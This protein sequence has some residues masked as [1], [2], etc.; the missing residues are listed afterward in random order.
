MLRVLKII[1]LLIVCNLKITAQNT[2]SEEIKALLSDQRYSQAQWLCQ[3][4]I[5]NDSKDESIYY[6]NAMCAKELFAVDAVYLYEQFLLEF[7]FTLFKN[8][9]YEDLA[10]IHL[11]DMYY[12][13]AINYLLK[14]PSLDDYPFLVFK[15][16]YAYFSVDSLD[17]SK[18]YFTKLLNI[19]SKY[20]VTSIYYTAHIDY[21]NGM[22]DSALKGFMKLI[23]DKQFGSIVPYYI[24]Q[25]YFFQR[26]YIQLIDFTAPIIDHIVPSRKLEVNRLLAESYYRTNQYNNAVVYFRSYI[27]KKDQINPIV[28]F[29]L[30]KSYFEISDYANAIQYLEK[31]SN[32]NDS[33]SQ[34]AA[35]SLGA[36][37][38][39]THQY[40]YALYAFK[41]ASTYS[42]DLLIKEDAYYNY[43]KLSYQLD[44][45]LD[46]TLAALRNYLLDYDNALHRKEV[47]SLMA[48]TFQSGS[49]YEEAYN[50][51]KDVT[52]LNNSQKKSFQRISF[53]L[54]VRE[55]NNELYDNALNYFQIAS[56]HPID[57]DINYLN[58]FWLADCYY[59]LN[60]FEK[61]V[62]FYS[63]L[64]L[65]NLS[66]YDFYDD[67]SKYNLAYAYFQQGEYGLANKLFRQYEKIANDSMRIQDT[68]LRIAD[69]FFMNKKYS[70][71]ENYY[72]KAVSYALFDT[73]YAMYQRSIA[74]GLIGNNSTKADLL[75]LLTS[76]FSTSI[77]Y[78]NGLHDLA[79]YYKRNSKD[80]LALDYYDRL[81][82]ETKDENLIAQ[83]YLSKG[84]IY[85]KLNRIEDAIQ[86]FLFVINNFQKTIYFKEALSG[87]Q[88][89]H[90]SIAKV[91][92]Y[93]EIISG[94]PEVSLS[95]AEQDSLTYNTA[96]IRF[97][98]EDYEIASSI[99]IKYL[100]KFQNGIFKMDAI[101]YNALSLLNVGDTADVMA[102]YMKLLSSSNILYKQTSISFLARKY[103]SD[104]DYINSNFYYQ[105]L[106]E[107]ASNN[108]LKRES[109]I[110]LMYGN[111]DLDSSLA[112][113]YA[114]KVLNLEKLD[115]WL[116]SRAQIIIARN[117]F[118]EGNYAKSK[119]TFEKVVSIS[120]YN[121][122]AEA[123]Y[124]LAYLSYL[125]DS[126]DLAEEMIFEL[127]ENY[128]SDY[129]IAKGFILLAEI[130]IMQNNYFQA[131]ATL[132]SVI[133][134]HN[135]DELVNIARKEWEII[136]ETEASQNVVKEDPQ[137]YIEI[138]EDDIDY[139]IFEDSIQYN[140]HINDTLFFR[141]DSL[142]INKTKN[143]LNEIE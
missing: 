76:D 70:L 15:L 130:Y 84:M 27:D 23:D 60:D 36:S 112:F 44:L 122:G 99:F 13:K 26:N 119:L 83:A 139:D 2:D 88:V 87:L 6:Y 4:L 137:S 58:S 107:A 120:D 57:E 40:N 50:L 71:A 16:A 46:N 98:D 102:M 118:H 93:L 77:Y 30:G 18:Y 73:D 142:K 100:N 103:Y 68:Y 1:F 54:A 25:I 108:S 90:V 31:V 41:K 52:E 64:S 113:S 124:Y 5:N 123:M 66:G 95:I 48:E 143:Y 92:D 11:R 82:S 39:Q 140:D 51:L 62:K 34:H 78:D 69:C 117:E 79:R 114:N 63:S 109:V 49:K 65:N 111:E 116:T 129:F 81:L 133:E 101:Y 75:L 89:A 12:S 43:V 28:Y 91:D 115:D 9:V 20:T 8:K 21:Q 80:V 37:Y 56:Q 134:N 35:Y 106:E 17:D 3:S 94:L 126:L 104:K 136:I 125:D 85:F 131:K 74:L 127:S 97:S 141:K 14:I 33:I 72:S 10:I 42:Y 22:Y 47:E 32:T 138:M 61:S 24:T 86:E 132:E 45:P 38:L 59:K 135:G 55:Y 105:K 29:L 53:L 110:R 7:P 121:E 19:D 67:L 128:S 96:F